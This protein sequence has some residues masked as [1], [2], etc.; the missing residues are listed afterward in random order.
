MDNHFDMTFVE[1]ECQNEQGE[2]YDNIQKSRFDGTVEEC[3]HWCY[4][5]IP[6]PPS[7]DGLVGISFVDLTTFL[8]CKCHYDDGTVPLQTYAEVN[9]VGG[10]DVILYNKA[11]GPPANIGNEGNTTQCYRRLVRKSITP[12]HLN[13]FFHCILNP[14]WLISFIG[15][16]FCSIYLTNN[17]NIANDVIISYDPIGTPL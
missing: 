16:D 7:V 14:L 8:I 6:S 12:N 2:K 13:F 17:V 10:T 5:I 4:G 3:A 1:A 9:A 11:V 15:V